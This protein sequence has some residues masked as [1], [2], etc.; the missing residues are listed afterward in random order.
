MQVQEILCK[1]CKD[2]YICK[3]VA[4]KKIHRDQCVKCYDDSVRYIYI[5]K[6]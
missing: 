4:G 2:Q 6:H 5:I 1:H 3:S